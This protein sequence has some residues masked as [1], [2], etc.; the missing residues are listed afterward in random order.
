MGGGEEPGNEASVCLKRAYS[1][2]RQSLQFTM[3]DTAVHNNNDTKHFVTVVWVAPSD[4][5][6]DFRF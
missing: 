6:Q 4:L 3:Q 2:E 5:S 1:H